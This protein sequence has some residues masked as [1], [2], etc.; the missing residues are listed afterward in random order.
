MKEG[1]MP[2][3]QGKPRR[4]KKPLQETKPISLEEAL[5][6]VQSYGLSVSSL[7]EEEFE[8]KEEISESL[9]GVVELPKKAQ[10]KK[11]PLEKVIEQEITLSLNVSHSINGE[12]YGPGIVTF[13]PSQASLASLLQAND[14][15]FTNEHIRKT[16]LRN[17]EC[18]LITEA[19][20]PDGVRKNMA[21][22]VSSSFF[23]SNLSDDQLNRVTSNINGVR[24]NAAYNFS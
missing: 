15:K 16:T 11:K 24:I 17:P 20:T 2:N 21:I 7:S 3:P 9:L 6:V 23:T 18:Y 12:F 22:P 4:V 5:K 19:T 1:N 14:L 10:R 13:P 8:T